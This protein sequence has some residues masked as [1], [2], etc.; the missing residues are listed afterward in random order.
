MNLEDFK[1]RHEGEEMIVVCNGPGLKNIPWAFIESRPYVA[2]N[3]FTYWGRF[4]RP[5]YWVAVD[6][7]CF[8]NVDWTDC[9]KFIKQHHEPRFTDEQKESIVFFKFMDEIEGF[10]THEE[11]GLSYSTSAI[12]A[13]HLCYYMG[14]CTCILV[15]FDCT[16]GIAKI[17][18][19]G[20]SQI[21]HWYDP[22]VHFFDLAHSWNKQFGYFLEWVRP[23]GMRIVNASVP[24]FCSTLPL[25][26]HRDFWD[27]PE[28][29]REGSLMWEAGGE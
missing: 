4:M 16:H 2:I 17:E 20:L 7:L 10:I 21:P 26:D 27:P 12:M 23:R 13:A 28:Q 15:G 25:A 9:P 11:Y 22:R 29:F 8:E 1:G 24:T 6:P 14:A 3:Y 19:H 5:D 18:H